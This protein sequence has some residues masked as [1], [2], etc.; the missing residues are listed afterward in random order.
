MCNNVIVSP[1]KNTKEG[2][3]FHG[4]KLVNHCAVIIGPEMVYES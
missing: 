3:Y 1:F 4:N 2:R